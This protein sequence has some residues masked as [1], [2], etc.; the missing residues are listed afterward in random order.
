MKLEHTI[1]LFYKP[2]FGFLLL[3]PSVKYL[4]MKYRPVFTLSTVINASYLN[5]IIL[6]KHHGHVLALS[7]EKWEN[8][9]FMKFLWVWVKLKRCIQLKNA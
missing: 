5:L 3:W 7:M 1:A 6:N 9:Q 8:Y 2:M 4:K